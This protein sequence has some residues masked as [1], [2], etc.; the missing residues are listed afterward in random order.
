MCNPVIPSLATKGNYK[1]YAPV[2]DQTIVVTEEG[3]DGTEQTSIVTEVAAW[4][5]DQT[6]ISTEVRVGETDQTCV[7]I[8]I[9][10]GGP[11]VGGG[12]TDTISIV[13]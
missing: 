9:G 6:N 3:V 1:D 5:T 4:G 7:V 10:V 8:K 13:T 11:G 2:H 12:G